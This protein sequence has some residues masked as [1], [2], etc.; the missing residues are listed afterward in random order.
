M[1]NKAILQLKTNALEFCKRNHANI[2]KVLEDEGYTFLSNA[3]VRF[4]GVQ[5]DAGELSAVA[6]P[7]MYCEAKNET[8]SHIV[9]FY[10]EPDG[11]PRLCI[12]T[13]LDGRGT[14]AIIN[15][16]NKLNIRGDGDTDIFD[17]SSK[18][19][20]DEALKAAEKLDAEKLVKLQKKIKGFKIV[21]AKSCAITRKKNIK[22]IGDARIISYDN[23]KGMKAFADAKVD[24]PVL[25][26]TFSRFVNDSGKTEVCGAQIRYVTKDGGSESKSLFGSTLT[27]AWIKLQTGE[28]DRDT[29]LT[30]FIVVE[31]YSTACTVSEALPNV[32]VYAVAGV[33]QV[34]PALNALKEVYGDLMDGIAVIDRVLPTANDKTTQQFKKMADRITSAGYGLIRPEGT[35]CGLTDTDFNDLEKTTG[36]AKT[37][38]ILNRALFNERKGHPRLGRGPTPGTA[39]VQTTA[40]PLAF[41]VHDAGIASRFNDIIKPRVDKWIQHLNPEREYTKTYLDKDGNKKIKRNMEEYTKYVREVLAARRD[42]DDLNLAIGIYNETSR[43]RNG[44]PEF[45]AYVMNRSRSRFIMDS[46]KGK[47]MF[48]MNDKPFENIYFNYDRRPDITGDDVEFYPVQYK[49]DTLSKTQLKEFYDYFGKSSLLSKDSMALFLGH[50]VNSFYNSMSSARPALFF[51]GGTGQGKSLMISAA[52]MLMTNM[53]LYSGSNATEAFAR[54]SA[55]TSDYFHACM[56]VL[57]EMG[58]TDGKSKKTLNDILLYHKDSATTKGGSVVGRGSQTHDPREFKSCVSLIAAGVAIDSGDDPQKIARHLYLNLNNSLRAGYKAHTK[59]FVQYCLSISSALQL[60][61]LEGAPLYIPLYEEL[62]KLIAAQYGDAQVRKLSHKVEMLAA[63]IAAH[64]ILLLSVEG[65]TK[66]MLESKAYLDKKFIKQYVANIAPDVIKHH[67][68]IIDDQVMVHMNKL[69]KV[70]GVDSLLMEVRIKDGGHNNYTNLVDYLKT[71]VKLAHKELGSASTGNRDR[72]SKDDMA[73]NMQRIADEQIEKKTILGDGSC[74]D[75][76]WYLDLK[77]V[78]QQYGV[79]MLETTKKGTD[80]PKYY[81]TVTPGIRGLD[82]LFKG[83][84]VENREE[85]D[86]NAELEDLSLK[87]LEH[88]TKT[89]GSTFNYVSNSPD[90]RVVYWIDVTAWAELQGEDYEKE[91]KYSLYGDTRIDFNKE[92]T[93]A[94][95][96]LDPKLDNYEP[97][98]E[99]VKVDTIDDV[100]DK[101]NNQLSSDSDNDLWSSDDYDGEETT[102]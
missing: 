61:A 13:H 2:V 32:T 33:N 80:E 73:V 10:S 36:K 24:E 47:L 95:P 34:L 89:R 53:C 35:N 72:K 46:T 85:R 65:V 57:E 40:G 45:D 77:N 93:L 31:S 55:S 64:A 1:N 92:V 69:G 22:P 62:C 100:L 5:V 52:R 18:L 76:T 58:K 23:I 3:P 91:V 79:S 6:R 84:Q 25:M 75:D 66:K 30:P 20:R 78:Q 87:K 70:K 41:G 4:D 49:T 37:F 28:P 83:S 14:I 26:V 82:V 88:I 68:G 102:E 43:N 51:D 48:D 16:N 42:S 44:E 74:I 17:E 96:K 56:M 7:P 21:K 19:I 12:Y 81:L 39:T 90:K 15:D 63:V 101:S 50:V 29:G 38:N 27:G 54:S 59:D 11:R 98:I 86:F 94:S 9:L 97:T 8:K 71:R 60:S 99:A 67:Q